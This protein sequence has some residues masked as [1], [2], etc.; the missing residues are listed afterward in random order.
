MTESDNE[1]GRI[2]E[3]RALLRGA[4][5]A[6]LATTLPEM[7]GPY[8]SLVLMA[9]DMGAHPLLL[10]SDL[11]VH[12]HNIA[13]S[14]EVS[15]LISTPAEGQDP[16]TCARISIQGAM[17]PVAD[18][19]CQNRFLRRYPSTCE[20]ASFADFNFYRLTIE[21]VHL[22][23]G[24][25][26]INWVEGQK[27]INRS[28]F[29]AENNTEQDVLDHMN[30]DHEDAVQLLGGDGAAK[31]VLCGVDPEGI[32]LR[33]DWLHKRILFSKSAANTDEVRIRLI[34]LVKKARN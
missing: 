1:T 29:L 27:V 26:R 16:L 11:A 12:S 3:I 34:E 30:M 9:T 21:R 14:P 4:T 31:W 28:L 19:T 24:F 5:T 7:G 17:A 33:A 22:V 13:Q 8:C 10:L 32:D 20:Y 18:T 25:G 2:S 23:A 6:S 15:L